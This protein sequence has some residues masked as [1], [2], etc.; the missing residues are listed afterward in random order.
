MNYKYKSLVSKWRNILNMGKSCGYKIDPIN[1][2]LPLFKPHFE[3][4]SVL[5]LLGKKL[6][7]QNAVQFFRYSTVLNKH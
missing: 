2:K 1:K 7:S 4:N 3:E 6:I 5:L